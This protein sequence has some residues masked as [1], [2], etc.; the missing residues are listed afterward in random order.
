MSQSSYSEKVRRSSFY[1]NKIVVKKLQDMREG[2]SLGKFLFPQ[3]VPSPFKYS[4]GISYKY[5]PVWPEPTKKEIIRLCLCHTIFINFKVMYYKLKK[6]FNS[7]SSHQSCSIEKA[8]LKTFAIFTEKH[9][10]WSLLLID[11][12]ASRPAN[13]LKWDC[14]FPMNIA[15]FLRLL[16][17]MKI[18]EQ[19]LL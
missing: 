17:L 13:F 10:C 8:V 6:C 19:L 3:E 7:R 15:K 16:I 12:R 9:L 5:L 11:L 2:K 18:C 1:Q 14:C 4:W